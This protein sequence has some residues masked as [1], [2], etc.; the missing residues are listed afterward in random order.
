MLDFSSETLW[1][2]RHDEEFLTLAEA[3]ERFNVSTKTI[4]RWRKLGLE[5]G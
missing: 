3:A 1:L 5:S 2:E 4:T